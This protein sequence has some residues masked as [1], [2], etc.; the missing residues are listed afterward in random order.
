MVLCGR[1]P[2]A[3]AALPLSPRPAGRRPLGSRRLCGAQES[4]RSIAVGPEQWVGCRAVNKNAQRRRSGATSA[5]RADRSRRVACDSVLPMVSRNCDPGVGVLSC[6]SHERQ[7]IG[8][9][10]VS[11]LHLEPV[12]RLRRKGRYVLDSVTL[13][14]LEVTVLPALRRLDLFRGFARNQ[15]LIYCLNLCA[16]EF[17]SNHTA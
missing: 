9:D 17:T 7:L 10:G 16:L 6:G 11:M 5:S 3:D 15:I 12:K 14:G 8:S 1:A 4:R 13:L 2:V